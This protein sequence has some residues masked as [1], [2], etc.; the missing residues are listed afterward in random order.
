MKKTIALLTLIFIMLFSVNSLAENVNYKLDEVGI[1]LD[2]PSEYLVITEDT[3][4]YDSVFILIESTKEEALRKFNKNDIYL[5]AVPYSLSEEITVTMQEYS[6]ESFN[7]F[8]DEELLAFTKS[9]DFG[10]NATVLGSEIYDHPTAKFLKVRYEELDTESNT[11]D[12]KNILCYLTV[13]DYKMIGIYSVDYLGATTDELDTIIAAI[14]ESIKFH[15]QPRV[16]PNKVSDAKSYKDNTSGV[17]FTLSDNWVE[18][19]KNDD[20]VAGTIFASTKVIG[21][22]MNYIS[23]DFWSQ[24]TEEEQANRQRTAINNSALEIADI[25]DFFG[26]T[27]AN[28]SSVTYN[29]KEYF[30]IDADN[31][32]SDNDTS[33]YILVHFNNGW[34]YE[35]VF[36]GTNGEDHT[37]FIDTVSS[38]AYPDTEGTTEQK[39]AA[40]SPFI[41]FLIIAGVLIIIAIVIVVVLH[42]RHGSPLDKEEE[43]KDETNEKSEE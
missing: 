17:S 28:V 20:S 14:A 32:D 40:I 19:A 2:I 25:A 42:H 11:E 1:S 5:S 23:I 15:K 3:P 35:F 10:K 41:Y 39:Q 12:K 6:V 31:E 22:T 24:L 29:G 7:L 43:H 36:N 30:R 8:D 4:S 16:L 21:S 13:Q 18:M 33:T 37:A 34:M 27:E 9:L 26:S 38:I